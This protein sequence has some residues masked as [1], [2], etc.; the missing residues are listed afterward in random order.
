MPDSTPLT[1]ANIILAVRPAELLCPHFPHQPVATLT[2]VLCLFCVYT[3]STNTSPSPYE[4]LCQCQRR[5]RSWIIIA[6]YRFTIPSF[7]LPVW[8][9]H[10]QCFFAGFSF[11]ILYAEPILSASTLSPPNWRACHRTYLLWMTSDPQPVEARQRCLFKWHQ[12]YTHWGSSLQVTS[13]KTRVPLVEALNGP[14]IY[15]YVQSY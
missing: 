1:A 7:I 5:R 8:R 11:I 10:C 12:V 3:C 14:Q 13:H 9:N 6:T 2:L 4:S 15:V